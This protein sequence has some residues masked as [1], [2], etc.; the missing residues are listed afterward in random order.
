MSITLSILGF[1]VLAGIAD[2]ISLTLDIIGIMGIE[3]TLS[4][5]QVYPGDTFN[6]ITKLVFGTKPLS[7]ANVT[8]EFMGYTYEAEEKENGTYIAVIKVSENAQSG[9]YSLKIKAEKENFK[10]AYIT[11][12]IHVIPGFTLLTAIIGVLIGV[13]LA[14]Q[15]KRRKKHVKVHQNSINLYNWDITIQT[16]VLYHIL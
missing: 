15:L 10:P 12:T 11:T 13:I 6:V 3:S 14:F 2:I 5:N 9:D 1:E 16:P 7:G 4:E 8:I